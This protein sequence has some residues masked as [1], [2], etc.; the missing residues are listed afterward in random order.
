MFNEQREDVAKDLMGVPQQST[1]NIQVEN[2][3][4]TQEQDN[5]ISVK[6]EQDQMGFGKNENVPKNENNIKIPGYEK[7]INKLTARNKAGE[8]R[9]SELEARI[10]Q[11]SRETLTRNEA[12]DNSKKEPSIS[13]IQS[14]IQK[15]RSQ[16]MAGESSLEDGTNLNV[17]LDELREAHTKSILSTTKDEAMKNINDQHEAVNRK[18][19]QWIEIVQDYGE[20]GI[21]D[22]NSPLFKLAKAYF[23]APQLLQKYQND[24]G[25]RLAIGDAFRDLQ[26]DGELN[27]NYKSYDNK[28]LKNQLA[29]EKMKNQLSIGDT[30]G[31]ENTQNLQ[32]D[33]DFRSQAIKERINHSRKLMGMNMGL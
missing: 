4:V 5:D 14:E 33:E 2:Q 12:E 7:R 3:N 9:I 23:Q 10:S 17:Y 19:Q 20:W 24:G 29:K 22:S 28:S 6:S 11:L 18:S 16:I 25:M 31:M 8:E 26:K 1:D 32:T 21:E 30:P 15:V 13:Q 27:I